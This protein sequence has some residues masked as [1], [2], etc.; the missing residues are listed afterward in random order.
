M[1]KHRNLYLAGIKHGEELPVRVLRQVW[2]DLSRCRSPMVCTQEC[3][4]CVAT[5]NPRGTLARIDRQQASF[6]LGWRSP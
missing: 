3:H 5:Q 4:E 2:K 1:R 6:L